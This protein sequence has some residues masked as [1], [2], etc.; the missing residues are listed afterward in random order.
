MKRGTMA[1]FAALILVLLVSCG[2]K[3]SETSSAPSTEGA[4][5]PLVEAPFSTRGSF[6]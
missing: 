2:G 4:T 6:L 1:L 3:K 5:G